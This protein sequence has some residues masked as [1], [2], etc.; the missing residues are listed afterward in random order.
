MAS[1]AAVQRLAKP[2]PRLVSVVVKGAGRGAGN[3]GWPTANLQPT[4]QVTETLVDVE[5]GV[6]C[7]WA[8]L[9]PTA[10]TPDSIQAAPDEVFKASIN[11]GVNPQY[12]GKEP[13]LNKI[14]EACVTKRCTV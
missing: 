11:V 4:Q 10:H 5:P 1:T 8:S 2:L 12:I 6:Y 3:L 13:A 14:A 7:G 9:Q